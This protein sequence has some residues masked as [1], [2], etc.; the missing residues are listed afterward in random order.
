MVAPQWPPRHLLETQGLWGLRE[1][2]GLTRL[3]YFSDEET[4]AQREEV[5]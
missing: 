1:T 3:S 4:E 5:T 2:A